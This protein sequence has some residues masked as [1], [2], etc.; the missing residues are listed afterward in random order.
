MNF[1]KLFGAIASVLISMAV[2]VVPQSAGIQRENTSLQV[3]VD[4]VLLDVSVQDRDGRPV[5]NLQQKDFKVYEDKIEQP[6]SSFSTEESS[7]TWGLVLDRSSSM[8]RMM[9]DVYESALNVIDQ[10]T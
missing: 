5:R 6:I 9:K 1:M 8:Q 7:V 10:G 2:P 4:L 3:A